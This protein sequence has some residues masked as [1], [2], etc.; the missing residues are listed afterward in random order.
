MQK[1][2]SKPVYGWL[3]LYIQ[4]KKRSEIHTKQPSCITSVQP[5]KSLSEKS[6]EIK[7]GGPEM[8]AMMLM[9]LKFINAQSHY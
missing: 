8:A 2:T 9:I 4:T 5:S 3:F 6:C 1:R 7:G